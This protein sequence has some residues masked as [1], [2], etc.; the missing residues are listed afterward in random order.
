MERAKGLEWDG[1]DLQPAVVPN[2]CQNVKPHG[3]P[4][5]A[6][7]EKLSEKIEFE[8]SSSRHIAT[9]DDAEL[10]EVDTAGAELNPKFKVAIRAMV[11]PG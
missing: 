1:Q 3:A 6:P 7:E 9:S 2:T 11:C 5:D 10:R 8:C 4:G